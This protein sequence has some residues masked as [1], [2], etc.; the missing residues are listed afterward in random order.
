MKF[1]NRW[2]II[3]PAMILVLLSAACAPKPYL[4]VQ[5]QL[6]SPSRT[7]EGEKIFLAID[8]K[9]GREVFLTENA[10]KK[11]KNF[12][13]TF[14]L[15]VLHEDGSGNLLGAYD[16]VSLLRQVFQ[17]RLYNAGIQVD[18]AANN[19]E[20]EL[21][22]EIEEFNLDFADRKWIVR[23][24]YRASLIKDGKI[25]SREAVSGE[26][27]RLKLTGKTD[28]EKTLG[29]LLSDTVNKLNLEGLFLKTRQ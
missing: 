20:F 6:P 26:A 10:R 22:I 28:A 21:K 24:K 11:L 2:M 19:A 7:L 14:S 13:G 5:Y 4:K 15:V 1:S 17:Q 12:S 3:V 29:E 27:E 23:M 8:D 18:D 25:L 16:F 9:R